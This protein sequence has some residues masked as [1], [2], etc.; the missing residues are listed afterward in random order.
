MAN[1]MGAIDPAASLEKW[2]PVISGEA[3]L[4]DA[5]EKAFDYRGDITLKLKSGEELVAYVFNRDHEKK[6]L[7]VYPRDV[8]EKRVIQYAEIESLSF[9]GIDTAA[10]KS[11]KAW[12]EKYKA[13]EAALAAAQAAASGQEVPP[14]P[15]H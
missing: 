15:E 7:Q 5:L 9:T 3:D 12:M 2:V 8:D 13:K 1:D 6:F 14:A 11:W 4:L 10:G